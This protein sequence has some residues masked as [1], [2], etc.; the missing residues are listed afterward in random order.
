MMDSPD[1]V[2]SLIPVAAS[3]KGRTILKNIGHLRFKECDRINESIRE[4]SKPIRNSI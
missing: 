4:F 1:S 2:L 3:A